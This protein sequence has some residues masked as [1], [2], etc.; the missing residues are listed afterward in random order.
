MSNPFPPVH[1]ESPCKMQ[2][3][4]VQ[5]KE[6]K[7]LILYVQPA[8]Y[9]FFHTG[10]KEIWLGSLSRL[11]ARITELPNYCLQCTG[12]NQASSFHYSSGMRVTSYAPSFMFF[13]KCYETGS[14][15]AGPYPSDFG[16]IIHSQAPAGLAVCSLVHAAA[17]LVLRTTVSDSTQHSAAGILIAVISGPPAFTAGC[18]SSIFWALH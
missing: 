14:A 18:R 9:V 15:A 12:I 1:Y 16:T 10:A 7:I 8:K 13:Y 17:C 2:P 5:A 11:P 3:G 4:S 6:Q